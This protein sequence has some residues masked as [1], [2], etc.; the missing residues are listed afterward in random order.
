MFFAPG[1]TVRCPCSVA[2]SVARR[3]SAIR[4]YACEQTTTAAQQRARATAAAVAAGVHNDADRRLLAACAC[5]PVR[6]ALLDA[7]SQRDLASARA[8]CR[9]LRLWVAPAVEARRARG[10]VPADVTADGHHVRLLRRLLAL[11]AP[12]AT[13]W[14]AAGV[15]ALGARTGG[16]LT[17]Q[18]G[19][20]RAAEEYLRPTAPMLVLPQNVALVGERVGVVLLES[21]RLE[22]AVELRGAGS[23][24]QRVT[25][26]GGGVLVS[27]ERASVADVCISGGQLR[28]E[29]TC[30]KAVVR[31]CTLMRCDGRAAAV[32]VKGGARLEHCRVQ[33]SGSGGVFVHASGFAKLSNVRV[34]ASAG[35]G[36]EVFG[37]AKLKDCAIVGGGRSGVVA[38]GRE[39]SAGEVWMRGCTVA[40]NAGEG[41]KERGT[42]TLHV[43]SEI[44]AGVPDCI[45][46]FAYSHS[47]PYE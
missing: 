14:L 28:V 36:V 18:S 4:C 6:V 19:R 45:Q 32:V 7:L 46:S 24:L 37:R 34:D 42:G 5:G 23:K 35:D 17:R 2:Q 39:G 40:G 10:V 30:A 15:Y 43:V 41:L 20:S 16:Q 8:A 29:G 38:W 47:I 3:C 22:A 12:G 31:R 26:S 11:A 13:V 44:P 21:G 25:T 27:A 9:L 33:C 1:E